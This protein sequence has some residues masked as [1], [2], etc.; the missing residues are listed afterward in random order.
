MLKQKNNLASV[1]AAVLMVLVIL[2][3]VGLLIALAF[4]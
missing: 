1:L 4:Q 3:V 2:G